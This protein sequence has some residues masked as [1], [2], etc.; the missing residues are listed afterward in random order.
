MIAHVEGEASDTHLVFVYGTLR[1]GERNSHRLNHPTTKLVCEQSWIEDR[2]YR[3]VD[4]GNYPVLEVVQQK[5]I[6]PMDNRIIGEVY[7]IS[8]ETLEELDWLEGYDSSPSSSEEILYDRVRVRVESDN[9]KDKPLEALVYISSAFVNNSR[10]VKANDW[11]WHKFLLWHDSQGASSTF[12][13]FA[14]GSCMDDER[15]KEASVNDLFE[16]VGIAK[17]EGYR[18]AFT[19]K[20]SDG[21]RA[22]LVEDRENRHAVEGVVY[23]CT[24]RALHY[25]IGREGAPRTYRPAYLQL[26][27]QHPYNDNGKPLEQVSVLSFVVRDKDPRTEYKPI[28]TYAREILRGAR[29][30]GLSPEYIDQLERHLERLGCAIP[31]F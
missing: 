9:H 22:D 27:L 25:L 13:Y 6:D 10:L 15:L 7:R 3:L 18:L 12:L 4:T 17:V 29:L 2:A 5:G 26:S 1:R 28:P 31:R 14:Y 30:R 19:R 23:K 20:A 21:G 11:K 16:P 24:S 8:S